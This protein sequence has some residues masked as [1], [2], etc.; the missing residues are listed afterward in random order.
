MKDKKDWSHS[1]L[2]RQQVSIRENRLAGSK[3]KIAQFLQTGIHKCENGSQT[4]SGRPL[5]YDRS[6]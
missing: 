2:E 5:L 6:G 4:L 1:G 3:R